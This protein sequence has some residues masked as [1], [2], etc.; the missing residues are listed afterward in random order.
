[1]F[2]LFCLIFREH[3]TCNLR[4]RDPFGQHLGINALFGAL[5]GR[6]ATRRPGGA[7]PFRPNFRTFP[8]APVVLKETGNN[9]EKMNVKTNLGTSF[10]SQKNYKKAHEFS[11]VI[12]I[13]EKIPETLLRCCKCIDI[14][15]SLSA[16]IGDSECYHPL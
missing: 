1:M 8:V 12:H 4:G 13:C 11:S 3:A 10:V 2:S 6:R 7:L 5:R 15:K 14:P 9:K 16:S